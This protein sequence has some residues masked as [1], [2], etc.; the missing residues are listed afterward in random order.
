MEDILDI[1][2]P[3]KVTMGSFSV[4]HFRIKKD[5]FN[6]QIGS[7]LTGTHYLNIFVIVTR[8]IVVKGQYTIS[9]YWL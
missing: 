6:C 7:Y 2:V 3:E 5:N 4:F 9:T 1:I 8:L